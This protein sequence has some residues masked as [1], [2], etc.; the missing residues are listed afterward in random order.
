MSDLNDSTDAA[1]EATKARYV[2]SY[3]RRRAYGENPQNEVQYPPGVTGVTGF[4]DIHAHAHKRQQDGP[5]LARTATES[6]MKALLIKTVPTMSDPMQSVNA[7]REDLKIWAD[8]RELEPTE[9]HTGW[10]TEV[11]LGGLDVQKVREQLELGVR[12]IW[13]PVASH[14][15]SIHQVGG[16][17]FWWGAAKTW[18]ELVGPVPWEIAREQGGYVLDTYGKLKPQVPQIIKLCKEYDVLLSIAHLTKQE[19]Q[20]VAD[21]VV[22]QNFKKA[23]FDHPLSPF[24]DLTQDEMVDYTRQGMWLNFTYDELSP[25][26]GVDPAYMY[27]C[28]R[29]VGVE[30]VTLSCDAGEPFFPNSVECMRLMK[31]YMGAFGLSQEELKTVCVDNPGWLLGVN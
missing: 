20:M 11:F 1:R 22:R 5:S 8:D 28:I 27:D 3:A 19:Q 21:E 12:G 6:Q 4:V 24:V 26:L 16:R 2:T 23:V 14:A 13:L 17:P 15:N 29:K 9:L 31:V 30:H 18:S 25:L 7:W 10:I